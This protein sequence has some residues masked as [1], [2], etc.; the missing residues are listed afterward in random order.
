MICLG[1]DETFCLN[2]LEANACGLPFLTFGKTA[3]N[4]Y[5]VNNYNSYIFDNYTELSKKIISI[6]NDKINKEIILN[7]F[8][9]SKGY[10]LEKIVKLWINLFK[11]I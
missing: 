7:S 11:K 8:N 5:S 6:S 3:L 4:D 10:R 2:A 9:K 1:Y